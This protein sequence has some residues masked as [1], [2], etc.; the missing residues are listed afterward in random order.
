M[1]C[2]STMPAKVYFPKLFGPEYRSDWGVTLQLNTAQRATWCVKLERVSC[3]DTF[4]MQVQPSRRL[5]TTL[6]TAVLI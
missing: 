2:I 6:F 3:G 4:A 1:T 5:G